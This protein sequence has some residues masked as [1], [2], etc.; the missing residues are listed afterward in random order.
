MVQIMHTESGLDKDVKSCYAEM[1][2]QDIGTVIHYEFKNG[3]KAFIPAYGLLTSQETCKKCIEWCA[4]SYR[5]FPKVK[6][7][8]IE[9]ALLAVRGYHKLYEQGNIP[10][11][12]R[13]DR[14]FNLE[15][16][17]K[18][19]RFLFEMDAKWRD[20]VT[21]VLAAVRSCPYVIV[22]ASD[23][24]QKLVGIKPEQVEKSHRFGGDEDWRLLDRD[25]L[26]TEVNGNIGE[27]VKKLVNLSQ[28][29]DSGNFSENNE[30][31]LFQYHLHRLQEEFALARWS[32]VGKDVITLLE[33]L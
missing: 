7:H 17:S 15:L 11:E 33:K 30:A 18:D 9:L 23:R 22:Y 20:D 2:G 26:E 10:F 4:E 32:R 31:L 3:T 8:D 14:L 24:I 13:N 21:I 19:G 16:V 25:S 1:H 12:L 5:F 29:I 27:D 6:K 28:K